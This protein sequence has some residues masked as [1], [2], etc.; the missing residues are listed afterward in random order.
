M[1]VGTRGRGRLRASH[2]DRDQVI[3]ALKA[4]F[5]QGRLSK[6][7][8]DVRVGQ[9]LASRTYADLAALTADIPAGVV[10]VQPQR[11]ATPAQG[12]WPAWCY[13][14]RRA[15]GLVACGVIPLA[16]LIAA[17]VTNDNDFWPPILVAFFAAIFTAGGIAATA[18]EQKH[19]S[20]QPRHGPLPGAGSQVPSGRSL[21][22]GLA[23]PRGSI[24]LPR[25]ELRAAGRLH[26]RIPDIPLW[27]RRPGRAVGA[28]VRVAQIQGSPED[29]RQWFVEADGQ[30]WQ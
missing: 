10:A 7:E 8:F 30:A 28:A 18:P 26:P 20:G 24:R 16:L 15:L 29:Q 2:A 14:H 9:A 21:Q 22:R 1:T 6:A 3:D 13:R 12:T 17:L 5:V 19:S 11:P 27:H 23:R 4:A 25:P